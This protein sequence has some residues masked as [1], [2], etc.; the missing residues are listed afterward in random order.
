MRENI[1]SL[2]EQIDAKYKS[3]VK[4]KNT[5]EINTLRLIKS[6]IQNQEIE[7]RSVNNP[8]EIND[9]QILGLMQNLIKQRRDSIESF[10]S[11]NRTDLIEIENKEIEIINQF[12]PKQLNEEETKKIIVNFLKDN[13]LSSLKD[14]GK[15]MNYLKSNYTGS[16]EMGLAGKLAKELLNI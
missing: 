10:K 3:S 14:M 11:A 13:N 7:N 12:L 8:I 9:Q 15:V 16:V 5:N 1:M 6:A 4:S 2:R